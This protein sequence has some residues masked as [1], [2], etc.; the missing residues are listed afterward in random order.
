[1]G[2]TTCIMQRYALAAALFLA[3]SAPQVP[4]DLAAVNCRLGALN[5]LPADLE[6]TS[7]ADARE[8]VKRLKACEPQPDAGAR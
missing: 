3:C 5:A 8:L 2:Q 7:I 4:P 6:Q 1:M